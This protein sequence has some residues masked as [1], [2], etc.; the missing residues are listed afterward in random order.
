MR[1]PGRLPDINWQGRRDEGCI[2]CG[3]ALPRALWLLALLVLRH[4]VM[5]IRSSI[6]YIRT[7]EEPE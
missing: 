4:P 2:D 5:I 1:N 6:H 3:D 7:G